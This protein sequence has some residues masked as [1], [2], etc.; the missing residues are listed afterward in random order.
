MA[1]FNIPKPGPPPAIGTYQVPAY[2]TP[3]E[4]TS[5]LVPDQE[6]QSWLG[7]LGSG[8]KIG[9]IQ[10]LEMSGQLVRG[11]GSG[12]LRKLGAVDLADSWDLYS[13]QESRR[14]GRTIAQLEGDI[15]VPRRLDDADGVGEH[16]QWGMYALA[17]QAPQLMTQ[18]GIAAVSGIFGGPTAA[19]GSFIGTSYLLGAGEVYSSALAEAG[20]FHLGASLAA[21]IPIALLDTAPWSRAIRRMGKEPTT[22]ASFPENLLPAEEESFLPGRWKLLYMKEPQKLFRTL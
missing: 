6:D 16:V 21:G 2:S 11:I 12:F 7:D 20:E 5:A 17:K 14:T 18:F 22:G 10:A 9:G 19:V 4:D 13:F 8:F 1:S 3:T 15:D